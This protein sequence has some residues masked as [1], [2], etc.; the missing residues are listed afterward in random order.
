MA[1]KKT[2]ARKSTGG[3][4]KTQKYCYGDHHGKGTQGL[5]QMARKTVAPSARKTI[6]G[7]PPKK[8]RLQP[9]VLALREIRQY[10][11]T[12]RLLIQH[13]PF[14]RLVKEISSQFK[15]KDSDSEPFRF[16]SAAIEALQEAAESYMVMLFEDTLH[17]A[18][19]AKRITIQVRDMQLARKLRGDFIKFGWA[20]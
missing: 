15:P 6:K 19:H 18:I 8:R 7:P 4:F 12:T 9:G 5:L 17:A 11:N 10:Q 13:L 2:V 14:Q 3:G 16:Q 20:H 1:R